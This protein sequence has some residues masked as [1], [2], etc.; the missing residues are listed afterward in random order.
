VPR[1][2]RSCVDSYDKRSVELKWEDSHPIELYTEKLNLPQ[3]TLMLPV[4]ATDCDEEY[5]TGNI[6]RV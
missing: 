5:K 6:R 1:S 3:F 4:I 2:L